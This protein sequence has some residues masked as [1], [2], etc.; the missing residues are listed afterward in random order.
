[1]Q[2]WHDQGY[3]TP[4][5]L[6][7][8]NT[9]DVEWVSMAELQLRATGPKIFLCPI[10]PPQISG[11]PG[12]SRRQDDNFSQQPF[13]THQPAPGRPFRTNSYI[14]GASVHSESPSSSFGAGR[15]GN[16]SPDPSG[17]GGR[18]GGAVFGDSSLASSRRSTFGDTSIDL[19]GPR[20]PYTNGPARST[21]Y[22][23]F[24]FN[25]T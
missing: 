13:G 6:M 4:D 12:L 21:S 5:L 10:I 8:R 11:P 24:G 2:V 20:S 14:N 19:A 16:N 22:D 15:F 23:N 18:A 1:M 3:F 17:F 9:L 25:G 7:K